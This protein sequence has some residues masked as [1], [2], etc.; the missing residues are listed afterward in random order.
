MV[1]T[2]TERQVPRAWLAKGTVR[3]NRE[4]AL[5]SHIWNKSREWGLTDRANPCEGVK[6]FKESGRDNYIDDSIYKAV[7][8][9]ACEPLRNAMD[10]AYLIGQRPADVLKITRADIKEGELWVTQNKTGKKLRVTIQGELHAVIERIKS[11]AHKVTSLFLI[12][13][14]RGEKLVSPTR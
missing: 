3:A 8:N 1:T 14:E 6:G 10:I 7:W 5:F 13:N 4:K 2:D 9:I 11:K 12:V